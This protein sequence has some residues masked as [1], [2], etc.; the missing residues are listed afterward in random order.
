MSAADVARGRQGF[1]EHGQTT[2]DVAGIGDVA[3]SSTLGT[4]PEAINTLVVL[5]GNTEVLI[6][7]ASDLAHV[8]GL[9]RIILGK[10]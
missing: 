8:E 2:T 4:G 6:S 7:V 10:I 9:A 3:Y 1:S 5:K